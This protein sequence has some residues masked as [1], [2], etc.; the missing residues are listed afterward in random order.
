MGKLACRCALAHS[1]DLAEKAVLLVNAF[2]YNKP[3]STQISLDHSSYDMIQYDAT[4]ECNVRG[5]KS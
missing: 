3:T 5:L 2:K 1:G 4:G